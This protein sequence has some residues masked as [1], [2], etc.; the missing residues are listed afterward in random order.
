MLSVPLLQTLHIFRNCRIILQLASRQNC[1]LF[2]FSALCTSFF[3]YV[4]FY[5]TAL[6]IRQARKGSQWAETVT[7]K[8]PKSV[9]R[10]NWPTCFGI[11]SGFPLFLLKSKF[12][13][14]NQQSKKTNFTKKFVEGSGPS[15]TLWDI[16]RDSFALQYCVRLSPKAKL[17]A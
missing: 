7:V 16:L 12:A 8:L 10:Q 11:S 14:P 15:G 17:L 2:H 1:I 13:W 5:C 4:D 9:G 3:L 6:C